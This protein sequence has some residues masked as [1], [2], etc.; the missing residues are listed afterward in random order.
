MLKGADRAERSA[1]RDDPD[2]PRKVIAEPMCEAFSRGLPQ[3]IVS[4]AAL[5]HRQCLLFVTGECDRVCHSQS[6]LSS[7]D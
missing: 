4:R 7:D 2:G 1:L 3:F 6:V 5:G